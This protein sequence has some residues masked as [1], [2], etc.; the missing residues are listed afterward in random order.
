MKKFLTLLATFCAIIACCFVAAC[1][2]KTPIKADENT[3]IITASDSSFDF[4]GKTLKNYMDYL[5]D[6]KQFTY[7]INNGMITTINGKSNTTNSYWMLYTSDSENANQQWGTFEYEGTI[8]G[9]AILGAD[10]L[11][12]KE[13]CIYIWAYQT[14]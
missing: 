10:V 2:E 12:V 7:S 8:Y 3:V 11:I 13:G 9:S 4:D 5:Q 14:F 1:G 6:N